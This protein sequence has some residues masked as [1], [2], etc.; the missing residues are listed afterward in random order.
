M[1]TTSRASSFRAVAER[2]FRRDERAGRCGNPGGD[3]LPPRFPASRLT[4]LARYS[5]ALRRDQGLH[6][7]AAAARQR[8]AY[9]EQRPREKPTK[10]IGS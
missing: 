10:P 6:Q 4:F 2:A 5:A 9:F 7:H 8:C 3:R 1:I